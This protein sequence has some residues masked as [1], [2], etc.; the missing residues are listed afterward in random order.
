MNTLYLTTSNKEIISRFTT[1]IQAKDTF[2]TD[3]NGFQMQKR[4]TK[5]NRPIQH[6]YY[7]MTTTF[8]MQ[9]EEKRLT[10]NTKQPLGVASLFEG[11]VE[12]MLD[13]RLSRDDGRGLMQG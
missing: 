11:T 5:K 8:F 7:P 12:L 2:F 13:R 3:L 4:K 10:I 9:D 6:N 1:N